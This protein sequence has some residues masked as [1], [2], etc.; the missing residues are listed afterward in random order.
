MKFKI[1]ARLML[2]LGEALISD[3]LVALMEL[4]KNSY[5]ADAN[6][7]IIKIDTIATNE[8]GKGYIEV[9]D[10]GFGMN[11][12]TVE[13]SFLKLA[14]DYKIKTS[15]ISPL[16]KRLSLGN[17]GI[18][19]L[20]LQR[21]GNV[22]EVTTKHKND[23]AIQFTIDWTKFDDPEKEITDINIEVSYKPKLNGEF[24]S[25]Q[26]TI[27]KVYGVKN[28]N[29]WEEKQTTQKFEKEMLSI[30]N[31]YSDD[32]S[33]F[34][35]YLELNGEIF[36]SEKY[37][38]EYL[39]K[40]AD[41]IVDFSFNEITKQLN[42]F[43]KRNKKYVNFR[44][45]TFKKDYDEQLEIHRNEDKDFYFDLLDEKILNF[46]NN[47]NNQ[48]T[49]LK[50]ISLLKDNTQY[51]L[52]GDFSGRFF[53]FD[54]SAGRFDSDNRKKLDLM[55]GVKL[56]RNN[57]RIIPYGDEKN[58]WLA[59]TKFSQQ[60]KSNLFRAHTVAGYVYIDGESNLNKLVEMTNRQGLIDD[61]YGRNFFTIMSEIIAR[62]AVQ[63]DIDF[64]EKFSFSA[65][66][67]DAMESGE[68][69][70]I[71]N[72]TIKIVRKEKYT[73]EIK[74]LADDLSDEI[75]PNVLDTPDT[76]FFKNTVVRKVNDLSVKANLAIKQV[77]QYRNLYETERKRLDDYRIV[78]GATIITESLAHE[79]LGIS[80]K[81]RSYIASIK[82]EVCK[83][84]ISKDKID[85]YLD[86]IVSSVGYLERYASVLDT[87]SYTKRKKFEN[88]DVYEFTQKILDAFP[89][90]DSNLNGNLKFNLSGSSFC[91]ELIKMNY[92][93]AIENLIVN[94]QYWTKDYID[95]PKIYIEID[96]ENKTVVIWDNGPGIDERF[97]KKLFEQYVTG[98]PDVA[99]R[100]MGL[101]ITKSL[102][103]EISASIRVLDE[104][105]QENRLFKFCITFD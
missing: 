46:N 66:A 57:F 73:E 97:E 11:I 96:S 48:L 28:I 81:I 17:K 45:D 19:R 4:I 25:N 41:T 78:V 43:V 5:D 54:K 23:D 55:N 9:K 3:E 72:E 20:A 27:I 102:L 40:F 31:P 85:M 8:Y 75:S 34:S 100:G 35:I 1:S 93:I 22:V 90:F 51:Y 16:F 99:G 12:S 15:K 74:Q 32:D 7:S 101:Y 2:H 76:S 82:T 64:R 30:I 63:S 33:K 62:F 47:I 91:Y 79:I 69:K 95:S 60:L 59:F 29:F 71:R 65:T 50:N 88:V 103:E 53:A 77:E 6:H 105:N 10:D 70:N 86:L 94:S 49:Y 104:R 44:F 42:V 61:N 83:V 92:K 14:T 36:S 52:P 87:N 89:L 98:K 26:G 21:L 24:K 58:D 84:N 80:K 13:N 39:E 67:L 38:V 56:F 37:D 18:G 68:S